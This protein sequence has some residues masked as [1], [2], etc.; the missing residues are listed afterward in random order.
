M[1]IADMMI[2]LYAAESTLLRVEKIDLMNEEKEEDP[3]KVSIYKDI[4]DILV[5]DIAARI[6]K[7]GSDAINSFTLGQ[8]RLLLLDSLQRFTKVAPVN[9][10]DKRRKIADKLID[11]NMFKF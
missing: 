6:Q 10:R 3:D 4:L 5:Y 2:D 9:V 11:D 7:A 8:E 1:N